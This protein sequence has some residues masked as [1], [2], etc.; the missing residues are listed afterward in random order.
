MKQRDRKAG[1]KGNSEG[2]LK[3]GATMKQNGDGSSHA[4]KNGII[5][6]VSFDTK[7]E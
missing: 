2:R 6:A 4:E 7:Y 3:E 1:Y 5:V